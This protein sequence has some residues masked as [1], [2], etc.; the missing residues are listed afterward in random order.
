[1]M[2]AKTTDKPKAKRKTAPKKKRA[3]SKPVKVETYTLGD[4]W[5]D[6]WAHAVVIGT[7]LAVMYFAG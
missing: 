6:R 1:M 2:E 7:M 5:R 4:Y 3:K